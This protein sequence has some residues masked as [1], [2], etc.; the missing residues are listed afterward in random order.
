M[1]L[2][3]LFEDVKQNEWIDI[4]AGWLQGRT[5][6]GGLVAGL[7]MQKACSHIQD[8][9]KRLLSCSVTFVGPVL[10]GSARLT[11]EV[12]R[13]GKSVTTLEARLWQ[14][15][16]VQTILVASF[17]ASRA[18]SI[19]VKQEPVAPTYV[20][21]E[22]LS[23]IP[24]GQNMPECFQHFEV[25]WAEGNYPVTASEHPDFGGWSRFSPEQHENRQLTLPDLIVLMDIWP[26]GVLPM[27]KQVAPASSLT[28]HIT[29][30]N[31]VQHQL[32]DWFKYKVVT[33]YASEGYSTEYAYL[34]DQSDHLIAILR[35]TVTVFT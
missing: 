9:N 24:F 31:P 27:F 35:Q 21:P 15:D 20:Q 33:E 25:C 2:L 8:S 26:P 19:E 29:Y 12:L 22:N 3:Q 23:V 32:C 18:S 13:E 10:Q 17:G 34:W 16:A 28:W 11:I 14:D 1:S 4:P 6:F 30:V 5:V 7:L